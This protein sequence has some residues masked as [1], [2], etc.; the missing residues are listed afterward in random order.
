[1]NAPEKFLAGTAA[2]PATGSSHAHES[3]RRSSTF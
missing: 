1:M 2:Q 3:A